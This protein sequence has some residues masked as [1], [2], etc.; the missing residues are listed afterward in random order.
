MNFFPIETPY[1]SKDYKIM[2][3]VVNMG[4]DSHLE[5]FTK[6]EFK[7]SPHWTNKFLWNIHDSELPILYRR[8]EALYAENGDEDYMDF[9]EDIRNIA[10]TSKSAIAAGEFG[11]ED[12]EEMIDPYDPMDANQ[13][14][15]GEPA[16]DS[17][18]KDEPGIMEESF[19][20]SE[21]ELKEMIK[22]QL[23]SLQES[24]GTLGLA[25]DKADQGIENFIDDDTKAQE[26]AAENSSDSLA[27]QH[28][29]N[30]KPQTL[31]DESYGDRYE[32]IIFMQGHEADEAMDILNNDGPEAAM[33]FLKQ[34]HYP[35]QHDGSKE[36]G[37][38]TQ[39]KTFEKDG[40]I[41]SWNP[42]LPYIGLVFDTEYEI[43]TSQL[44]EEEATKLKT[45]KDFAAKFNVTPTGNNGKYSIKDFEEAAKQFTTDE[46][47][48][49]AMILANQYLIRRTGMDWDTLPDTNSMWDYVEAGMT[50]T[51]LLAAA[52]DAANERLS[53]EG[54][55]MFEDS[56][57][58]RH[59]AG[60]RGKNVALGQHA[61]HSQA[62][63]K[64]NKKND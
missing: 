45:L 17:D 29:E 15:Q 8:I 49:F 24:L 21:A 30:L 26:M 33:E 27:N 14:L 61:P 52:Q 13:T 11:E 3:D 16:G 28:G 9:L 53:E 2:K 1:D 56:Q 38:G 7:K 57:M 31:I 51:E 6:S 60:Q 23:N 42:Y 22:S 44:S 64:E 37:H 4:I 35:G 20:V 18:L 41:M 46:A 12:L 63:I 50:A 55:D 34:W 36:L 43:M 5:G 54:M 59:L 48:S 58:K 19:E 62:A 40:Y 32:Q 39:D 10:D 25:Y 47:F